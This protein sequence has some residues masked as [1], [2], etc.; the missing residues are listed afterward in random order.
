MQHSLAAHCNP[1]VHCGTPGSTKECSNRLH[2]RHLVLHTQYYIMP[3][4]V[5]G[6]VTRH[7]SIRF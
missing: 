6:P 7:L 2:G 3:H 5:I 1:I 4:P